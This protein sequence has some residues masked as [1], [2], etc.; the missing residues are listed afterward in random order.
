MTCPVLTAHTRLS[1]PYSGDTEVKKLPGLW[2]LLCALRL[3]PT[4]P[5]RDSDQ[6]SKEQ[7]GQAGLGL[8]GADRHGD[9]ILGL[10]AAGDACGWGGFPV[11][12]LPSAV[13]DSCPVCCVTS[14]PLVKMNETILLTV[15]VCTVGAGPTIMA[16]L[17][18]DRPC[19]SFCPL[20][21]G[22]C[23]LCQALSA[24]H[25]PPSLSCSL[26]HP[27]RLW[28]PSSMAPTLPSLSSSFWKIHP[29]MLGPSCFPSP[30]SSRTSCL[31]LFPV[32]VCPCPQPS[33]GSFNPTTFSALDARLKVCN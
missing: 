17:Q 4:L 22:V 16:V 19:S 27:W 24:G 29:A 1:K 33:V 8:L 3:S 7:A 14:S 15:A 10:G 5:S 12:L 26:G 2:V 31:L 11:S 30:A 28:R 23:V 25:Q 20:L 13:G 9:L 32:Q 18:L 6:F 21:L